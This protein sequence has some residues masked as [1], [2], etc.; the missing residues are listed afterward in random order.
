[1]IKDT[2]L[3]LKEHLGNY[4]LLKDEEISRESIVDLIF[5][6]EKNIKDVR[7]AG[8]RHLPVSRRCGDHLSGGTIRLQ[9]LAVNLPGSLKF[10]IRRAGETGV[11]LR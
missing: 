3:V 1:M 11:S 8:R 9:Q 5:I 6:L 7:V 4:H 2:M 10:A